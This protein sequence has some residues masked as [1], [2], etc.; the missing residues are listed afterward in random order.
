MRP[1]LDEMVVRTPELDR[2]R[3]P[4]LVHLQYPFGGTMGQDVRQTVD[5]K[6]GKTKGKFHAGWD[7][8]AE[9]KTEAFAITDGTVIVVT[10][11][12]GY[13]NVALLE[14]EFEQKTLYALYAH[15]TK[16]LVDE[17]TD[18]SE[19]DSIALTGT[20]GNAKGG[21]PHLHFEIWTKRHVSTYPDGRISPGEVIGYIFDNMDN[22]LPL[23]D[24]G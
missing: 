21:P 18:V 2:G 10:A 1:P 5:K 16:V 15:L 3:Y 17:G 13:G 7:L 8:Y 9:P 4:N 14:F 23:R 12:H 20:S 6:T 11:M 24:V 22:R 19:G